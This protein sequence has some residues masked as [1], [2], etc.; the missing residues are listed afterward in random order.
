MAVV[1]QVGCPWVVVS[2]RGVWIASL[3]GRSTLRIWQ[4]ELREA[5][6]G[7]LLPDTPAQSKRAQIGRYLIHH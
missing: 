6:V 3:F 5:A 4:F 2:D 7:L 1:V